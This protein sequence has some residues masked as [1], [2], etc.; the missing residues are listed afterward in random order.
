MIAHKMIFDC[1]HL[2]VFPERKVVDLV[3]FH[4][5]SVKEFLYA[6]FLCLGSSDSNLRICLGYVNKCSLGN[7][8][9]EEND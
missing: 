2:C 3:A 4:I 6:P 5:H 9:F 8:M 1:F 7:D